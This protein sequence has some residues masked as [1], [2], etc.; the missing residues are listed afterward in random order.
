MRLWSVHPRYLDRQGLTACWR[1]AL[2]AQAVLAGRTRGYTRHPQL[3]RFRG[4]GRPMQAV[5]TYLE[6]LAEQ[7]H[8]RGYR[9]DVARIVE[10]ETAAEP[11]IVTDGQLRLEWAHLMTKLGTRTPDLAERWAP[12]RVPQPHPSFVV[13]PG[14]VAPWERAV[15]DLRS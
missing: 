13:V 4:H 11:M 2:L 15:P 6:G 10:T 7:A 3:E 1:E 9:F 8:A 14:P 12:V 5:G